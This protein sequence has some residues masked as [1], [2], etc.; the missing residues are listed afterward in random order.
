MPLQGPEC[1]GA[2]A[3]A[4]RALSS[5][6]K[7]GVEVLTRS[8]PCSSSS[9]GAAQRPAS[10]QCAV[11]RRVASVLARVIGFYRKCHHSA[12]APKARLPGQGPLSQQHA[13]GPPRVDGTGEAAADA[14]ATGCS[15]SQGLAWKR[16]RF[17]EQSSSPKREQRELGE[18]PL[19]CRHHGGDGLWWRR[20][21]PA[22]TLVPEASGAQPALRVPARLRHPPGR[23]GSA[24]PGHPK[25]KRAAPAV[26][27]GTAPG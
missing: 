15:W 11:S 14:A 24:S 9:P 8:V 12:A 27:A 19:G 4:R 26:P 10:H 18:P 3:A 17:R 5:A 2:V 25:L 1:P 16:R 22:A 13:T 7:S 23:A 6:S 21:R 20:N